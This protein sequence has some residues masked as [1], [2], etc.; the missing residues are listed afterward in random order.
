MNFSDISANFAEEAI[1][2]LTAVG[3]LKVY[4][5]G[6]FGSNKKIT[7]AEF[8]IMTKRAL[9]YK[10][11]SAYV[12]ALKDFAENAWY[13]EELLTTLDSGI[14]KG[15]TNKMYRPDVFILREQA[16]VMIAN[17]LKKNNFHPTLG[18]QIFKDDKDIASWAN[19][20]V[21]LLKS[22]KIVQGQNNFFYPKR[23]VTRAEAAMMIYRMLTVLNK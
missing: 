4:A 3:I 20:S 19:S 13:A 22:H 5:D 1:K 16:A 15:F 9:R 6:I 21:Y 8:T 14:T 23:E 17:V 7:R 11:S 10:N 18:E 12:Q 2:H